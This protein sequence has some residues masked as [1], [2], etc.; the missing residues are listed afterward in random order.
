MGTS[1]AT[2][3]YTKNVMVKHFFKILT[4]FLGMIIL[5]LIGVYLVGYFDKSGESAKILNVKTEVAK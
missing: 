2:L 4:I 5:G 3:C 1:G